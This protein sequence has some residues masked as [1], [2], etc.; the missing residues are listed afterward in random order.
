MSDKRETRRK[1]EQAHRSDPKDAEEVLAQIEE[2]ARDRDGL[3]TF[4]PFCDKCG[5]K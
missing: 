1:V 2:D 4:E 3:A 5:G